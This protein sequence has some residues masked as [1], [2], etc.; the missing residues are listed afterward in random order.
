MQY[1]PKINGAL[2]TAKQID[3][4]NPRVYLMEGQVIFGTPAAFGGGKDKAKPLFEKAVQ[5]YQAEK[6]A[7]TLQ[8]RW[9]KSSAE[10]MLALC[11]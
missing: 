2:A 10:S 9:G 4:N 1:A 6:P 8:P 3:P 5:L 7:S 11:K